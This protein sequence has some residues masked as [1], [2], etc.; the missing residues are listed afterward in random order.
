MSRIC[1]ALSI[2]VVVGLGRPAA[3]ENVSDARAHYLKAQTHYAVG[4]FVEAGDEYQAAYKLKNDP[5]LLY[6]AAQSFRLGGKL[7]KALILYRNYLQ[8]YPDETAAPMVKQRI[9]ELKEAIASSEHAK[10]NPPTGPVPPKPEVLPTPANQ[11]A[12]PPLSTAPAEKPAL[13]AATQTAPAPKTPTYKKW[14]VWTIVGG[15][16]AAGVGVG[17]GLGLSSGGAQHLNP[18]LGDFGPGATHTTSLV[19]F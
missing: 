18:T 2:I 3:A 14:W 9:V 19:H 15:V 6:D 8:F 5:A 1:F 17:L 16:A 12:A 13:V 7:D 11:A 10:T 4:E